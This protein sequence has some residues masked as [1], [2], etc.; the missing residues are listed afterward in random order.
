MSTS[1]KEN[2]SN[3]TTGFAANRSATAAKPNSSVG[4]GSAPSERS[5]AAAEETR[6]F[7]EFGSGL[8]Y[9]NSISEFVDAGKTRNHLHMSVIQGPENNVHYEYHR[10]LVVSEYPYDA[11]MKQREAIQAKGV[12][13]LIR[14]KM[15]NPR[16]EKFIKRSG[17]DAGE[18]GTCIGGILTRIL[19]MKVDG[20]LVFEDKRTFK[21]STAQN[22][23]ESESS[24]DD[25]IP[26]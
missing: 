21:H 16:V 5:S 9:V 7:N 11:I 8:A 4:N 13:V 20:E 18:L 6:Y 24:L 23:T 15:V 14:F 17:E 22:Q 3:K 10:L 12:K 2:V 25:D 1:T 26:F 19:T